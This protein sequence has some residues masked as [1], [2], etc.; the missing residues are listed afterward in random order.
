MSEEQQYRT[1]PAVNKKVFRLGLAGNFGIDEAGIEWALAETEINYL[2]WTPRMG[3]A[4]A[5]V[6]RA[7]ARDR[8]RFVVATGP[9]IAVRGAGLRRFVERALR[10]LGTEYLDVLQ[11]HWLGFASRWA[12][13]T[14]GE[15]VRL[16]EQGMVRALG[17][18]IHNRRRAG[19][20]A[21]DSPLDVLM[22]RYNAAHPGAEQDIFPHVD[23]TR[24]SV[25]A[26][27]ATRWRKL[28]KRPR[29]WD[30]RV[31][32]AGDCYRF[33]LT[34]AKVSVVLTGPKTRAMLES[35]LEAV[36]QGPLAGDELAWMR[37]FGT[38]VHG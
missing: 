8:D 11:M 28:L 31:P 36:R 2:F 37:E 10:V 38:V 23:V 19:E 5:P 14:V 35:N 21:A 33:C 7:L 29:G 30:G 13:D 12:D 3:R 34:E 17:V 24:R 16:R 15:M 18:S 1:L 32:T 26:Y 4:T 27:T 20:L 9:T 25:V 22:V 6:R